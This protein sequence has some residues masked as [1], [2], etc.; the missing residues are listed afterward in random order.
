MIKL[1]QGPLKEFKKF[2]NR[3]NVI[4]MAVGLILATYFGAIIKSL[5]YDVIMPPIGMLLGKTDFSNFNIVL[6]KAEGEIEEVA[7]N[8]GVFINNVLTFLIVSL[9]IFLFL[10]IYNK[11]QDKLI[12]N[13]EEEATP[14][15]PLTKEEKLLTEIRDLLKDKD[16]KIT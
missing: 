4:E 6:Q 14:P 13:E 15:T 2:I 1:I 3:G 5:V 10:K 11:M 12:D 8:Y 7:I 9:S 16:K